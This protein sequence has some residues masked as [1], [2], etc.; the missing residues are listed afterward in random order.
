MNLL[1][2]CVTSVLVILIICAAL[3]LSGRYFLINRNKEIKHK[4]LIIN[5]CDF[6]LKCFIGWHIPLLLLQTVFSVIDMFASLNGISRLFTPIVIAVVSVIIEW[7]MEYERFTGY[8]K[9]P[10]VYEHDNTAVF[11]YIDLYREIEKINGGLIQRLS[12]SQSDLFSQ[13]ETTNKETNFIMENINNYTQLQ[14]SECQNLLE[15]KNDIYSFFNDLSINIRDF[16][17]IFKQYEE[18][19]ENSCNALVYYEKGG[20]LL[21]DINESFESKFMQSTRDFTRQLEH[22][23]QQLKRIVEEYSKFNNLIK[24]HTL[25]I[26]HYNDRMDIVLQSLRN[27]ID[28]RQTI[29]VDKSKE[30]ADSVKEANNDLNETLEKLNSYLTRNMFVLS[31][32]FNTYKV[33]PLTPR[34][35]KKVIKNWPFITGKK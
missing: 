11:A 27:G 23:E 3:A 33:N 9:G 8:F 31:K 5:I 20:S 14:N 13:F 6:I 12:T 30:I 19:L 21:A 32:I 10:V 29:L 28:T 24:P 22:I 35:V 2:N 1:I 26:G 17:N 25:T 16:C 34:E 18:K 4:Q 15:I 7:L